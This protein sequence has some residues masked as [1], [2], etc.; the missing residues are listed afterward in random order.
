M[1]TVGLDV[2]PG[3]ILTTWTGLQPIAR[4]S[5]GA[6]KHR[7][8]HPRI[9]RTRSHCKPGRYEAR[10]AAL[11][12]PCRSDRGR[13]PQAVNQWL[14]AGAVRLAAARPHPPPSGRWWP[15]GPRDAHG[16]A[17]SSR[18][19]AQTPVRSAPV[20]VHQADA[21]LGGD[22][23]ESIPQPSPQGPTRRGQAAAYQREATIPG[24]GSRGNT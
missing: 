5:S 8:R 20:S 24:R 11:P 7:A 12:G 4:H 18:M 22:R 15:W 10:A 3:H 2:A 14:G 23:P 6:Y 1:C 17:V 13:P 9:S 19:C 21:C 16:R